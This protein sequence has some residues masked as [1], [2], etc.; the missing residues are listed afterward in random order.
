MPLTIQKR[1]NEGTQSLV[2][3]F[4]RRV[5]RSSILQKVMDQKYYSR[6]LSKKKKREEAL[7]KKRR[8]EKYQRLYKLGQL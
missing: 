7:E 8:R 1:D 2:N 5:R 3:R 4:S 6:S